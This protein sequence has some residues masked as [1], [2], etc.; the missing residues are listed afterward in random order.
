MVFKIIV[1]IINYKK[2]I[3]NTIKPIKLCYFI[4]KNFK[5]LYLFSNKIGIYLTI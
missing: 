4:Y 1:L 2:L 3:Q 5:F